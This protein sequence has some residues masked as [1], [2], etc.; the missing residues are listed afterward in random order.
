MSRSDQLIDQYRAV[1]ASKA[2]GQTSELLVGVILRQISILSKIDSLLDYGCGQSR[3]GDWIGKIH[4]ARVF[5]Y[6]PAIPGIDALPKVKTDIVLCTDVM[7]HIPLEN[8]ETVLAEIRDIS[9]HAFFNISCTRAAE[10]LPNG[11]NAHCTVRPPQWWKE[12][13][14]KFWTNP[15]QVRSLTRNAVSLV[16]WRR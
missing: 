4:D 9:E 3:A 6:D 8:V 10:I 2:Y 15:R 16:T 12:K 1:H 13:L 5:K 7:E 14:G 11:E